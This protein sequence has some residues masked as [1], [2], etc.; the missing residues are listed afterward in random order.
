MCDGWGWRRLLSINGGE[1]FYKR[2]FG[3]KSKL[4]SMSSSGCRGKLILPSSTAAAI[5]KLTVNNIHVYQDLET[6]FVY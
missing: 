3:G 6:L 5:H 4:L 1:K 2:V